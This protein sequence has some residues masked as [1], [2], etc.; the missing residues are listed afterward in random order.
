MK[1]RIFTLGIAVLSLASCRKSVDNITGNFST[2]AQS[3]TSTVSNQFIPYT[4]LKGRQYCD[5]SIYESVKL[6]HL[7]FIVKFDSSAIYHTSTKDNQDD[8]NKLLGFSDN[9]EQHHQYSVRFG[10][11]WSNNALHLFG[12]IYNNGVRSSKDLG[13]V[14]I[15]TENSASIKVKDNIYIFTLNGKSQ[16]MLRASKTVKGEGYKL[17]PY[18]GGDELAPHTIVIWIKE[19]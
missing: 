15:G 10:W 6:D 7:S 19:L 13:T 14:D 1:I 17:F 5:K 3:L 12:Y 11:R 16:T 9:N 4:I 18:F 8:I 2:K